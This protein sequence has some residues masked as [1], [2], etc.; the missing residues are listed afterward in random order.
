MLRYAHFAGIIMSFFGMA[1]AQNL[2]SSRFEDLLIQAERDPSIYRQARQ[3]AIDQELPISIK[4][5]FG[6]LAYPIAVENSR[7]LYAVITNPLHPFEGGF[8]ASFEEISRQYDLNSANVMY[9]RK[10]GTEFNIHPT[11]SNASAPVLLVPDWTADRVWAFDATTGN[12]VDTAFIHSNSTAL[13]SPKQALEHPLHRFITVSDQ[14]TD[15]VQKFNPDS[16]TWLG[17]FA[18][19]TGVNNNILDNIRGHAYRPNNNLLVTVASGTNSNAIA[20]F[21]TGGNYIGNFIGNAVGGLNSPF[22][23]LFRETDILISQSSSPTGVKQ[24]SLTGTYLAQWATISSFPQQMFRMADGRIAVANF[25]G[26][27]STGIRIY[28]ANGNFIR[29]LAGVTGNRGVYQLPS[30]NFLT[31]NSSGIH[32]IDSTTGNLIRTIQTGTNFQYINLYDPNNPPAPFSLLNPPDNDTLTT[33]DTLYYLWQRSIDP[34]PNDTVRYT[35]LRSSDAGSTWEVIA[36]T[37]DTSY[38]PAG[39]PAVGSYLWTVRAS[40]GQISI[41]SPDTF[42]YVVIPPVSISDKREKVQGFSLFQNFPNPF[43]P[44]TMIEYE[45]PVTTHVVVKVYNLLGTE[46]ATLMEGMLT[47]GRY[48]ISWNAE[49]QPAGV[50]FYRMHAGNYMET[51]KLVLLK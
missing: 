34:D 28:D 6:T 19:S 27:G 35:L 18:P 47:P 41:M 17:W 45:I 26:T 40:D 21:D 42:S 24:Y 1:F 33:S 48:Q 22:D 49:H 31:T 43:N 36:M 51:K 11:K 30:G 3:L 2:P 4:L 39:S 23:I 32:E 8:V 16:G 20:E 7:L 10:S 37:I 29:L 14:I 46:I 13:A 25:S 15:L 44:T 38:T 9:G 12:L 5:P 50:Y